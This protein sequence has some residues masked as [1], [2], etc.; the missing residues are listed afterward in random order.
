MSDEPVVGPA[1]PDRVEP[2]RP[3]HVGHR[4]AAAAG[5]RGGRARTTRAAWRGTDFVQVLTSPR[6]R[7]RRTAELAGYADAEVDE[8]LVEWAYGDY[9]GITTA[10]I[11]ERVPDW[12]IWSGPVPGGESA[13]AGGRAPRPGRGPRAGR[14][15]GDPGLRPRA[16]A[17]G[18]GRP[19]AG[20]AGERGTAA[21][22][23]HRDGVG[24]RRGARPAGRAAL[25]LLTCRGRGPHGGLHARPWLSPLLDPGRAPRRGRCRRVPR[26]R[27]CRAAVASRGVVVRRVRRAPAPRSRL[28]DVPALAAEPGLE[29]HRL[30]GGGRTGPPAGDDDVLLGH[31]RAWTA[32]STCSW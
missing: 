32:R 1:R 10:E 20:A 9:E 25:E 6:Q 29:R 28:P 24:A 4:P 16:L 19:L 8:D 3:A 15:R 14:R 2:G 7:A 23:G 26:A 30:R 11:R 12:T 13:R 22:A 18:A 27:Q 31:Q 21:P 17:A 5:G